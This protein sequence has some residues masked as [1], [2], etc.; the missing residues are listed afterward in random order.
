MWDKT[1]HWR[2][3]S[4]GY[5]YIYIG[6]HLEYQESIIKFLKCIYYISQKNVQFQ[7]NY[8]IHNLINLSFVTYKELM[9]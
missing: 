7:S 5:M 8:I 3:L 2:I 1:D 4:M 6:F 9:L